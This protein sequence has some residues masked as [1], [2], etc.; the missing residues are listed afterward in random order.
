MKKKTSIVEVEIPK[1]S[2]DKHEDAQSDR[3]DFECVDAYFDGLH[4]AFHPDG[5][6]DDHDIDLRCLSL[7]T[8]FLASVGWTEEEYWETVAERQEAHQCPSCAEEKAAEKALAEK[9]S[10]EKAN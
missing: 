6:E 3:M 4:F 10:K 1:V 7:W 8:L 9:A 2:E 5:F